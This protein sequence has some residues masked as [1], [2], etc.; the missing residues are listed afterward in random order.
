M[1]DF[2]AGTLPVCAGSQALATALP[3]SAAVPPIHCRRVIVRLPVSIASLHLTFGAPLR[4]HSSLDE[5]W[6]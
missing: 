4:Q 1:W 6:S 3:S 5:G 2:A